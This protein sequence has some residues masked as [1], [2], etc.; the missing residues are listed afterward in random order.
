MYDVFQGGPSHVLSNLLAVAAF[1][2]LS[3]ERL[4]RYARYGAYSADIRASLD[5]EYNQFDRNE[6]ECTKNPPRGGYRE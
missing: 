5:S 6:Q 2:L 3:D 1:A 4:Q